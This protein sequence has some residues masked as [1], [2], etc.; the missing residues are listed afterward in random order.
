MNSIDVVIIILG[1]YVLARARSGFTYNLCLFAGMLTG[2]YIGYY[3]TSLL[4]PDTLSDFRTGLILLGLAL[5]GTI[6]G[7]VCGHLLGKN[8]RMR[9]INSRF[10][11]IDVA[12][13]VP[14]KIVGLGAGVWLLSQTLIFVPLPAIQFVAQGSS[15][16]FA[17]YRQ[18]TDSFVGRLAEG[19][20]P[21]MYT[22]RSLPYDNKPLI[23]DGLQ[24]AEDFLPVAETVAPYTVKISGKRCAGLG[25]AIGNGTGF[26]VG[27]GYI[28]TNSHV[29]IGL[30]TM[31]IRVGDAVYPGTPL[32]IDESQDTAIVYVAALRDKP[33]LPFAAMAPILNSSVV[34]MGYPGGGD[35]KAIKTTVIDDDFQGNPAKTSLNNE[36]TLTLTTGLGK[37]SSG[38]PIINRNGEVAGA[39]FAGLERS[40][41]AFGI[42]AGVLAESLDKAKRKPFPAHN[43]FCNVFK[44]F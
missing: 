15:L 1:F 42:N 14:T 34:M 25:T 20:A 10:Y 16:L 43:G 3:L 24:A 31:Y 6:T 32:V 22:N 18:S 4:V 23:T 37:G 2:Y 27:D 40:S 38:G 5:I 12:V 8:L 29:V 7:G 17:L 30:S 44:G 35:L 33:G 9:V 28:V 26:L 39:T 36:K 19:I 41:L 11:P 21:T 13:S